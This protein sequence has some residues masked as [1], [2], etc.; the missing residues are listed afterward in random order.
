MMACAK[1]VG[2]EQLLR[3]RLRLMLLLLCVRL[4]LLSLLSL[5][6]CAH[7]LVR[8]LLLVRGTL[9]LLLPVDAR[10]GRGR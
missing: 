5:L 7:R 4:G 6:L 2:E 1:Q 9:L 10:V 8:H 3:G